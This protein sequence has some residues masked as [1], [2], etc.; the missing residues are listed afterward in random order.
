MRIKRK[1]RSITTIFA[2]FLFLPLAAELFAQLDTGTINVT[3][4]DASGLVVPGAKVVLRDERTGIDTRVASTNEQGFYSFTLIPSS[5]YT[6][7]VEQSGFKTYEQ[8]SVVLQVNQQLS[9]PV[10]LQVGEASEKVSVTGQAPLVETSSGVLRETI[11]AVRVTELPLNGRNL[12]QLQS[13][14]PG[15]ISSGS[16]D[17]GA[18]TPGYAVNGGIG[19]S[20]LYS[21]DGA[22]YQDSYFN[23][24]LPFPNPDAMQEF[25]IQTNSYSAEYGRNRGANINAVTR[26]GTN[27]LHG[28]AFEFVRNNVFDS[29]PFF[30]LAVPVFKRNQFGAQ[31]GGP[32]IKDKTFFFIAWQGTIVRGTPTTSN[33]PDLTAQMR[34]GNFSQLSKPIVDPLNGSPFPGNIIPSSR[35]STPA[36]NFLNQFVPLPNLG[37]NYVTPQPA[38]QDS[39]QY[40]GRIDHELTSKDRLYGRYIFNRDYL[41]SP[42]GNLE[43]WGIDQTFH[44]QGLVVGETHVFTPTMINT[45]SYTFNRVYAYIVQTPDVSWPALGANIPPAS[46]VTHSWQSLA[47]SGYFTATTGTFWNLGRNA[48]I[49]NDVLSWNHGQHTVKFGGAISH[50]QVNQVN[51]FY[52]RFGGTFTGFATGN[53]AADFM[54]GDMNTFR[55][56]SVL[57]NNLSQTLWQ[58][59]VSDDIRVSR[60]LTLNLGLRWEPDFHFTEASG[61]ESAFRPGLQSTVFPNAPLG[62]LFKGDKQLPSNV[63]DPT[64]K[65]FAPRFGF[66]YDATGDGKM[67]I[68]GGY[69]IF[70]DDFASIHL[71][72]FP[73]IQPFVLDISLFSVNLSDPFAGQSPF[74]FI[75]PTTTAQKQAYQFIT[76]ANTTS[77]NANFTTPYSQQ[78]N[79]NIQRQLPFD[80]V[81]TAAYVGSKSDRLF[82][83]HNLNPAVDGPGAT[84]ANTQA[85]RIYQQFG[86]IEEESTDGY[87]QYHSFQLTVNKRLSRG[88]TLL[89]A[90]TFSKDLGLTSPQAEG[91]LG[92]RDPWNWNL[93]KGVL[94][95]NRPNILAISSVWELPSSYG[96]KF[97]KLALGGWE[98]TGIFTASSGAPL[99]VRAGTDQSLTG[100]GLDTADVVGNWSFSQ[101]RSRQQQVMQWFNTKAFATPA[102]G[103]YGTSGIDVLPGPAL[104]NLDLALFRNFQL[105]ERWK[106]QFRAEFFNALNHPVLGN[107]NTTLNAATFGQIT[108]TQTPPRV[109]ELGLKFSF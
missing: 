60:R 94:S 62:L 30:S 91:S 72:R 73:L 32:I 6:V 59:F 37:N 64:L 74:P 93:D 23:A 89:A 66:A 103:T 51:E 107:P 108:S 19:A 58:P 76:P 55:E 4:K 81:I 88:F 100:Q 65:N 13:L 54:L 99:T 50:Y 86:T 101:S 49:V 31:L 53:A 82:G 68:R 39:N 92:T 84:V 22:E 43:N 1:F 109:G 44:R 47:I 3:V 8:S 7:R 63:I 78:W 83:S 12:L 24:P 52:S 61:K 9:I 2:T 33:A 77:F 97:L 21:L 15:S 106:F 48:N 41:F 79:F 56:V 10:S 57:S 35:L 87:S 29:R 20:N 38:P 69:G 26:S 45:V 46:P 27:Q 90:Y 71:N 25:T 98:L 105:K 17:Q 28:G 102:L 85:R 96:N 67:S 80:I 34:A 36:V 5:S 11:D 42:A 75:P 14:I 104:S 40:L 18:G 95:T 16:L 70:Y